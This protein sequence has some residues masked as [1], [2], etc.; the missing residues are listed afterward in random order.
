MGLVYSGMAT[1]G[2]MLSSM[3]GNKY[4]R[5]DPIMR[6]FIPFDASDRIDELEALA[7][8]E[9]LEK[10]LEFVD[11]YFYEKIAPTLTEQEKVLSEQD[12]IIQQKQAFYKTE[13]IILNQEATTMNYE[14]PVKHITVKEGKMFPLPLKSGFEAPKFTHVSAT[15]SFD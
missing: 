1:S 3:L 8:G 2:Q 10:T 11:R 13:K 4:H 7:M 12:L 5:V 14:K 6:K 15:P 9:S